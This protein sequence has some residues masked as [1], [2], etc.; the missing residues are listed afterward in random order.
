MNILF[1]N[2]TRE[3]YD[4]IISLWE[5][6]G[7]PFRP[8]GRD[9]REEMKA[10]IARDPE[11]FIGAFDGEGSSD[12]EER[13]RLVGVI[14]GTDDGRKGWLNRLAVDPDYQKKGIGRALVEECERCLRQRGRKIICVLVEDW[15]EKSLRLFRKNDYVLHRDIL[16]LSKRESEKV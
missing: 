10:Q 14:V 11:L 16:Y 5:R 9:S 1:H 2:L 12:G 13:G 3:D 4:A 6:A 8:E 15:N 7:L